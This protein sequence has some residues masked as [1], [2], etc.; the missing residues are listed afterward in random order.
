MV[1]SVLSV[2]TSSRVDLG[3]MCLKVMRLMVVN[4]PVG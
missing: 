2:Q 1:Y 4:S 3:H